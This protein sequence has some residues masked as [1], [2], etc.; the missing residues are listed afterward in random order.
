METLILVNLAA[1]SFTYIGTLIMALVFVY[2][3]WSWINTA[4]GQ[5]C[6]LADRLGGQPTTLGAGWHFV[7]EPFKWSVPVRQS[8]FKTFRFYPAPQSR[9]FIDPPSTQIHTAD[10]I[11]GVADIAVECTVE[12]WEADQVLND[13]GDI[14]QRACNVLNQWVASQ[15]ST[16]AAETANSY[17]HIAGLLNEDERISEL[18]KQLAHCNTFLQ[19]TRITVDKDGIA[20]NPEWVKNRNEIASKR[21]WLLERENILKTELELERLERD[22]QVEQQTFALEQ[23]KREAAAALE[24]ES[25]RLEAD[26]QLFQQ[27]TA[28][29]IEQA[30]VKAESAAKLQLVEAQAEHEA[31]QVRLKTQREQ[32]ETRTELERARVRG[33]AEVGVSASHHTRMEIAK[34]CMDG[35]ASSPNTKII[36]VPPGLFGFNWPCTP[37]SMNAVK[38]DDY[39]LLDE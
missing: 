13:C 27:R 6:V 35:I 16:V 19:A 26:L 32:E 37:H 7:L 24:R 21:Q 5:R 11:P 29:E 2:M 23:A 33:L 38:S 12:E 20:L 18:N 10:G 14:H 4:P 8:A 39:D 3:Y 17:G 34:T 30:A 28:H 9:V 1:G 15:L 36:A 31:S 22:K 25:L